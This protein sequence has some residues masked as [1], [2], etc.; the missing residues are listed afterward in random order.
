MNIQTSK[1]NKQTI[2]ILFLCIHCILFW[3]DKYQLY[4]CKHFKHFLTN[5]VRVKW[6]NE[7]AKIMQGYGFSL[8]RWVGMNVLDL[9]KVKTRVILRIKRSLNPTS[10]DFWTFCGFQAR[11]TRYWYSISSTLL[12]SSCSSHISLFPTFGSLEM[13]FVLF[14]T[15]I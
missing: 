6:K 1:M 13:F 3:K 11:G 9:T 15:S 5:S 10:K 7:W 4:L 12:A 8:F 2:M 14:S